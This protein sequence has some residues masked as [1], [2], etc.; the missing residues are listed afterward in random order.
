MW[1]E[2]SEQASRDRNEEGVM[3]V[4]WRG[5]LEG[6]KLRLTC[7]EYFL[8]VFMAGLWRMDQGGGKRQQEPRRLD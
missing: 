7:S 8:K 4:K 1:L 2:N 6:F 3:H 5:V